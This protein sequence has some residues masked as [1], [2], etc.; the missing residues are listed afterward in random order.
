MP[1]LILPAGGCSFS[2]ADSGSLNTFV[3]RANWAWKRGSRI[4]R[5][6]R[7]PARKR[8]ISSQSS[9][10]PLTRGVR[11]IDRRSDLVPAV[12]EALAASQRGEALIEQFLV[13]TEGSIEAL[14]QDGRVAI[15]GICDKTKSPLPDRYDLELRYPGAY[16]AAVGSD[17]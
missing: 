12:A 7:S 17:L 11:W 9:W 3:A 16:D 4:G 1:I 2:G 13:G 6:P 10:K 14:V 15:L 8:T 5:P